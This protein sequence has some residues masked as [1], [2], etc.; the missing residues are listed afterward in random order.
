MLFKKNLDSLM[1][2]D[3]L[4]ASQLL[5]VETN[6]RFEVFV[7]EKDPANINIY[8]KELDKPLY[9]DIPIDE[10]KEFFDDYSRKYSRYP[11]LF[12]YGMGNGLF[13]K[14]L[15]EAKTV[16]KCIVIEPNLELIYIA[17]NLFDFSKEIEEKRL[18]II[19]ETIINFHTINGIL[20]DR[21]TKAF[22]K[23]YELQVLNDYYILNYK[24]NILNLNRDFI[25]QIK[26]IISSEGN[27]AIDSLIGLDHHLQNLPKM[28]H[29]Y[30]LVSFLK[31]KNTEYAVIV[32]T[33]PSLHKQLPLLR[34]YSDYITIISVDASLPI[35][36]KERIKPDIVISLERVEATA[37]FFENLDREFLKD[38]IFLPTSLSHPK[39]L[40][41]LEGFK[42]S[43][44]MRK[45]GY[46][47]M[48]KLYK[49]G[50]LGIGLSAANAAFDFVIATVFKNVAFIG[51]DLAFAKD[52][53]THSKGAIYGEKEGQYEVYAEIDGYYGGTVKTSRLWYLFLHHL[54]QNMQEAIDRGVDV[55]NC[56]EGGAYIDGAKHIPFSEFL[57]KV[58]RS[59][60]KKIIELEK[61]PESRSLHYIKRSKKLICLY[62][63]RLK[64]IKAKVEEVFLDV[65]ANIEEIEKLNRDK[66]VEE[67]DFDKIARLISKID[68]I[69]DIYEDD[70]VLR[71]FNNITNPYILHAE[72]ELAKIMV[73]NTETEYE[74]KAKMIDWIYKHKDWLFFL[75]GA[76]ENII[77]IMQKNY[78]EIYERY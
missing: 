40:K 65:M 58:D 56:T 33:G 41:N 15:L 76:I 70:R 19:W 42:Q 35:L 8:D 29:S 64:E 6:S 16:T 43:I 22:L 60:K 49:W 57:A 9:K 20:K 68:K 63:K 74:K 78:D 1:K 72:L 13:F 4:L 11:L 24:D 62:L 69:K 54:K 3:P 21:D 45:F 59:K 7:D 67:I 30:K 34:E 52:G 12:Y 5:M 73:Q 26:N 31:N 66:R 51:Q 53:K 39:L 61:V 50:Y 28:V 46:T 23:L 55:Y 75:A 77:I 10:T 48:F 36:Q 38:T 71:R 37:K 14:L 47:D 44:Y 17:L 32:S 2:T 27:D 25:D 18:I